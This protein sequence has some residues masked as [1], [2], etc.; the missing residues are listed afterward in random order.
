MPKIPVKGI[1]PLAVYQSKYVKERDGKQYLE[2][3]AEKELLEEGS[4]HIAA[5]WIAEGAHPSESHFID[6]AAIDTRESYLNCEF[7]L[8]W[9]WYTVATKNKFI[10]I[11]KGNKRE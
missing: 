11:K 7:F 3:K 1:C 4:C 2:P 10:S 9:F 5:L 8:K 6:C